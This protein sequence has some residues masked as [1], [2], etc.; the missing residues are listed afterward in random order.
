[1]RIAK[2]WI[3]GVDAGP[4]LVADTFWGRL[5][6]MLGRRVLPPA[7]LLRP[8]NSVHGMGMLAPLDVAVL[9]DDGVVLAV[10]VLRPFGFTR[11]VPGGR[12]VLEAP[13]GSFTAWSLAPG[14]R[15]TATTP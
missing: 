12:Q 14:T 3:D 5:R 6:G 13:T 7:L 8:S 11:T 4:V 15:V 1:M 9:D 2:L 10:Q